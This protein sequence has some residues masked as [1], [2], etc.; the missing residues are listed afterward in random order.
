MKHYDWWFFGAVGFLIGAG[1]LNLFSV[2]Q[3]LFWKQLLW[4]SGGA[5]LM[6]GLPLLNLKP[7]F[8]Y[9][10]AVLT[11][12]FASIG[13]LAAAYL[14]APVIAHTRSWLVLG[15]FQLQPCEFAKISLIILLSTFFASKHVSIRRVGIV[16]ASFIYFAIPAALVLIQPDLGTALVLFAIWFGYLLVSEIPFKHLLI[17]FLLFAVV[18]TLGWHFGLHQYQK[19]RIIGLFNPEYDPLG[20]NYQVIQAKITVGSAGFFGKGFGQGTQS[21]LGFLVAK[22]NDFAFSAFTEE[23]GLLGAAVLISVF[24]FLIYRMLMIGLRSDNNFS[25]F[26]ALGSAIMLIAH[27]AIN[28]GSNLGLFPVVGVSFPFFSY[29]GS[30]LLTASILIGIIQ[31]TAKR[32]SGF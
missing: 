21:H 3:A 18:A 24:V 13:L 12:Y 9:R 11:I 22:E 23:W 16:I 30:N 25:K 29:G 5:I 28:V 14:F 15:G 26:F 32:R 17:M 10:W 1:L 27:F 19:E 4:V 8:S 20:V 7:L 31:N 6:L 2:D